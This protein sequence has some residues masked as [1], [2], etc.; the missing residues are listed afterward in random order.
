MDSH[1][2]DLVSDH[3]IAQDLV[4]SQ[5]TYCA[6]EL[7]VPDV[8]LNLSTALCLTDDYE[9]GQCIHLDNPATCLQ[10]ASTERFWSALARMALYRS[11]SI[12]P[13]QLGAGHRFQQSFS[14]SE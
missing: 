6:I 11:R 7:T 10:T 9:Q 14:A 5:H 12:G 1:A 13:G 4:P 3:Q 8:T 2:S